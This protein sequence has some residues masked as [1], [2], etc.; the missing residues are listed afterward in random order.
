M[1]VDLI[2]VP[3]DTGLGRERMGRGPGRLLE[4]GLVVRLEEDGHPVTLWP[5]ETRCPFRVEAAVAVDL[6]D[7]V[8]DAVRVARGRGALPLVL[9]G[10]CNIGVGTVT[11]LASEG[12]PPPGVVWFD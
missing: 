12:E 6:A 11:A 10:N 5:V 2:L 3:Y 4:A 1:Q 9:S 8:A 7:Q